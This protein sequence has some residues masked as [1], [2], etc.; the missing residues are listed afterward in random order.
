MP[1]RIVSLV[2]LGLAVF[3]FSDNIRAQSVAKSTLSGR[4]TNA[5]GAGIS[6]KLKPVEENPL[7]LYD[8][9]STQASAD[10]RFQF[11]DVE[12]GRYLVVAEA[13]G[14]CPHHTARDPDKPGRRSNLS[15]DNIEE[16]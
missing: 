6:V 13:A 3:C 11:E 1:S 12:P 14:F 9:Y 16:G 15:R 5:T 7:A 8:G 4:I 2:V 10:G